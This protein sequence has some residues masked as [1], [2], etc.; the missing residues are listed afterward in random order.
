[1]DKLYSELEMC[2]LVLSALLSSIVLASY[3]Y[4][5]Q[6]FPMD[7]KRLKQ[8]LMYVEMQKE[9]PKPLDGTTQEYSQREKGCQWR[10]QHD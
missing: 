1:M 4:K 7:L 9:M 8:D 5:G 10:H 3:M 6:R 2:T